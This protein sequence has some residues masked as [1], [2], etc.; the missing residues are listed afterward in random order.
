MSSP[1]HNPNENNPK[2]KL[3][4]G[5]ASFVEAPSSLV[6]ALCVLALAA[7][8]VTCVVGSFFISIDVSVRASGETDSLAGVKYVTALRS[9]EVYK[10]SLK[11]ADVVAK[12]Q[13]IGWVRMEG[14]TEAQLQT[15]ST[16][17]ETKI[18]DV[19]HRKAKL[20]HLGLDESFL[21]DS[22][23]K[24]LMTDAESKVAALYNV[25][26]RGAANLESQMKPLRTR[27]LTVK[28]QLAYV[29]KSKLRNYLVMQKESLADEDGKLTQQLLALQNE[30]EQRVFEARENALHSMRLA[31]ASL[32]SF[33]LQHQLRAPIDGQIARLDIAQGSFVRDQQSVATI[34]PAN[35]PIIAKIHVQS[36]DVSRI[37]V[38]NPC[39][40]D[41]DA[42]PAYK[43]GYFDG[44]VLSI[45]K[46]KSE[47]AAQALGYV[48][49]VEINLDSKSR[50][51]AF[52]KEAQDKLVLSPG[53]SVQA[54]IITKKATLASLFVDKIFGNKP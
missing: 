24:S 49:R 23:L 8:L 10:L 14:A 43:Y 3:S 15:L 31:L 25:E 2:I 28:R 29:S 11:Q 41:I 6:L 21:V 13:L 53:M 32:K 46:V 17:L 37:Q 48:A 35:S 22:Q 52:V 12:D 54:R 39:S 44:K 36:Q 34:I 16:Q 26:V 50:R 47:G 30:S 4:W 1:M 5:A 42:F 40:L 27:Q 38:G 45:E 33:V 19:E 18:S 51:P 7:S 20:Q 9:G